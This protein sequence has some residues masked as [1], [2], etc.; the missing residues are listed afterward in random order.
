MLSKC[1]TSNFRSPDY[2]L[3]AFKCFSVGLKRNCG[4]C[5]VSW[6]NLIE[7]KIV[8]SQKPNSRNL[9]GS[10]DVAKKNILCVC[11]TMWLYGLRLKKN[12]HYFPHTVHYFCS[13]LRLSVNASIFTKL[14]VLR[15]R[16][17]L[18]GQLSSA[19]WLGKY[20]KR[21]TEMLRPLPYCDV[22]RD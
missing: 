5:Q 11:N 16:H 12:L 9:K 7:A 10:D 22:R 8:E 15:T 6:E 18:I 21:E 3:V 17:A 1:P 2:K 20:L 13:M 14:F 4:G 19:L